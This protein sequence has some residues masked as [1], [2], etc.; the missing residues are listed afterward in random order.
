MSSAHRC[1]N[2]ALLNDPA[3]FIL[4]HSAET[5]PF[6]VGLVGAKFSPEASPG[7]AE[8]VG[9]EFGSLRQGLS[10]KRLI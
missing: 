2:S 5:G 6:R 10:V 7:Q 8:K 1:V 3:F 9:F 4:M